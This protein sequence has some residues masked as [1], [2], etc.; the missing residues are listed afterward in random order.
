MCAYPNPIN[1][2]WVVV[3]AECT[4]LIAYSHGPKLTN[5]LQL[6]RGMPVVGLQK[7]ILGIGGA[8]NVDRQF[9]VVPPEFR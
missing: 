2:V 7:L 5:A 1:P 9:L 4:I 3:D 6:Q 8:T